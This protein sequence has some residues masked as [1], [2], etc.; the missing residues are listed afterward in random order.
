MKYT[1]LLK[2][3]LFNE[4][5]AIIY[6]AVQQA[7]YAYRLKYQHTDFEQSDELPLLPSTLKAIIQCNET[8]YYLKSELD[9]WI[10]KQRL[11]VKS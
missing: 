11:G 6:L 9:H 3:E 2:K 7:R 5:E 4:D 1:T 10:K 8:S